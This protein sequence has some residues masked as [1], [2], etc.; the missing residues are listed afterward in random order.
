M[1]S[2]GMA[3]FGSLRTVEILEG[4]AAAERHRRTGYPAYL[5]EQ[6]ALGYFTL[7]GKGLDHP[8]FNLPL[9]GS[10]ARLLADSKG[11]IVWEMLFAY[12]GSHCIQSYPSKLC[13]GERISARWLGRVLERG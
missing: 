1:L 4:E 8:L 13:S 10:E 3:Q 11:F 12:G 6:C 7:L 9:E 2:E 5:P